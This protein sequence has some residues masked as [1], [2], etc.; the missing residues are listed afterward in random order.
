MNCQQFKNESL[1][2]DFDLA[3]IKY[4]NRKVIGTPLRNLTILQS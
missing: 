2:S 4:K 1:K 3:T